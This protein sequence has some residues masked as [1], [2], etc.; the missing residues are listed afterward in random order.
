[1]DSVACKPLF[2]SFVTFLASRRKSRN[3]TD[4]S[5]NYVGSNVLGRKF[6]ALIILWFSGLVYVYKNCTPVIEFY[7]CCVE[8]EGMSVACRGSVLFREQRVTFNQS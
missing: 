2:F 3:N 8:I 4:A 1:M 6:L 5:T 7:E